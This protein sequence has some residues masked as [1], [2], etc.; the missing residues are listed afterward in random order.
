MKMGKFIRHPNERRAPLKS[1]KIDRP[2]ERL[3]MLDCRY[4]E[5]GIIFIGNWHEMNEISL[6]CFPAQNVYRRRCLFQVATRMWVNF[7]KLTDKCNSQMHKVHRI[8]IENAKQCTIAHTACTGSYQLRTMKTETETR[9]RCNT[10]HLRWWRRCAQHV[11][12]CLAHGIWLVYEH[13]ESFVYSI[14]QCELCLHPS[15]FEPK[16]HLFYCT[17][18]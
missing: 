7:I 16:I 9:N 10:M 6:S 8:W 15:H 18:L 13:I 12:L 4:N 3:K 11:C 2:Y 14:L 17:Y 5:N 1:S